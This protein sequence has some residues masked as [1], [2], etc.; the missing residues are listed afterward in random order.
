MDEFDDRRAHVR[1]PVSFHV[2]CRRLGPRQHEVA[3]TAAVLDLSIGGM[4]LV[5]PVWASVGNVIEVEID[6]VGVRGLVVALSAGGDPGAELH[7][8]VAFGSLEPSGVG[9]LSRRLE[10]HAGTR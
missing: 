8:H 10:A 6:G 7:A 4:R 3:E 1:H 2:R 9:A 5:A